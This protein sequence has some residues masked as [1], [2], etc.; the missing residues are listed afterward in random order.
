MAQP[1]SPPLHQA[2]SPNQVDS[3]VT[4]GRLALSGSDFDRAKPLTLLGYLSLEG[5][6][7][8]RHLAELFWPKAANPLASLSVELSRLK[9]QLGDC[10]AA[11]GGQVTA[12]LGCDVRAFL[13]ALEQHDYARA[14]ELYTGPFLD[15]VQL[16]E[17]SAELTEWV[18]STR[19]FLAGRVCEAFLSLGE[20]RAAEGKFSE[21]ALSAKEACIKQL[22]GTLEV[23]QLQRAYTLLVAD[24]HP[25][26]VK[27]KEEARDL[28]VPLTLDEAGARRQLR[29]ARSKEVSLPT[30]ATDFIGRENE[31]KSVAELLCGEARLVSVV[32]LAGMGKSRLA[33]EVLRQVQTETLFSGGVYP[34]W[35]V[36]LSRADEVPTSFANALDLELT[37]KDVLEQLAQRLGDQKS[38]VYFDNFEHVMASAPFLSDLLTRCPNLSIL[39][40]SRE[41]LNLAEEWVV[42]LE[43]LAFERSLGDAPTKETSEAARLF[44][45]R[46]RRGDASFVADEET[47]KAVETVCRRV[48]GSPLAIELAASWTRVMSCADIAAQL[49]GDLALLSTNLRNVP[50][51]HRS[52]EA[53]FEYS[54][55]LLSDEE[56]RVLRELSVFR[57]GFSRVAAQEVVGAGLSLLA[58]LVDKSLLVMLE[59]GRFGRH[60]LLY[61]FTQRRLAEQGDLEALR[62]RHAAYYRAFLAAH[63]SQLEQP[64]SSDSR[65]VLNFE[66]EVSNVQLAWTYW[67]EHAQ[68]DAVA[69]ALPALWQY[70]DFSGR[71]QEGVTLFASAS[72]HFAAL[73]R[74]TELRATLLR[75]QADMLY[76]LSH[77]EDALC[78]AQ[79]GLKLTS[80]NT[81]QRSATLRVLGTIYRVLRR[82][83]EARSAYQQALSLHAG[84]DSHRARLLTNLASLEAA[85]NVGN[86]ERAAQLFEE[87]LALKR[88]LGDDAE[89]ART[90][91]NYAALLRAQGNVG[92]SK[93]TLYECLA[94]CTS[95]GFEPLV[96]YAQNLLG[97]IVSREGNYEEGRGY[98][99]QALQEAENAKDR[100]LICIILVNIAYLTAAI[101]A[102]HAV[103][104]LGAAYTLRDLLGL[105]PLEEDEDYQQAAGI[106]HAS[107]SATTFAAAWREGKSLTLEEALHVAKKV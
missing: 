46:A 38:L 39:V 4:L 45:R 21:A 96:P 67:L 3:L 66:Q 105:S 12:Q 35:L 82:T 49:T 44:V 78:V 40:T 97:K 53:A 81:Y 32:G 10:V 50:E 28:G 31:I 73:G 61:A 20:Q 47:R 95:S 13:E 22:T 71:S 98:L 59:G 25:W 55:Q 6:K 43:G 60:P 76:R 15:G 52:I 77:F 42:W 92:A 84:E 1:H 85:P 75:Y 11:E 2:D 63:V 65:A 88:A 80:Q 16:S 41:R 48:E 30:F 19:E 57:G 79:E 93:G 56:R 8:R 100:Y 72:D 17:V 99:L 103:K 70:F 58:S 23:E 7:A 29:P 68:G 83:G 87:S 89:T 18:Y 51:R 26:A 86:L 24:A 27:L 33:V 9:K 37:G 94:K 62:G 14:T 90:L 101:R 69:A 54:W 106:A 91:Y 34:V 64:D 74:H 102:E 5:A 107:L 104:L 36:A